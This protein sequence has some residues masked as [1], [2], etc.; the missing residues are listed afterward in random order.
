ML[1]KMILIGSFLM[2]PLALASWQVQN[3]VSNFNF[4]TTKAVAGGTSAVTEVQVVR[5]IEGQVDDAG[6]IDL[7]VVL[8][9]IATGIPLRDQRL[10]EILFDVANNPT[11]RFNGKIDL[12]PLQALRVGEILDASLDGTLKLN[13]VE[14][15]IS[16]HIRYVRLSDD[17]VIV[18]T[19]EPMVISVSDFGLGKGVETLRAMMGLN[20]LAS[21][22]PINF[23]IVLKKS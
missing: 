3:E 22:A 17:K 9:S 1:K 19:L 20:L 7:E 16:S 14:K 6:N 21:T 13:G 4:T 11:A 10:Q 15:K 23:S 18:S 12:A 5:K 8:G 2:S